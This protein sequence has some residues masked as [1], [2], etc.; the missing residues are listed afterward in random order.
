M[1][2]YDEEEE[3]GEEREEDV[4]VIGEYEG[5]RNEKCQRHGIGRALL[6]N[7]DYY[8]GRYN[9]GLRHGLGL[10]IFKNGARYN[11]RYSKGKKD[12]IGIFIYPDGTKYE[13]EWKDDDRHGYGIYYYANGDF[14]EGQWRKGIKEGL[15]CYFFKETGAKYLGLWKDGKMS[16]QG[17]QVTSN[18]RF[19]GNWVENLPYGNGCF[20]FSESKVIQHGFYLNIMG[21]DIDIPPAGFG[22][23]EEV[24]T[25]HPVWRPRE[26]T[27]FSASQLP[28]EPKPLEYPS[29]VSRS[30]S[31]E[32]TPPPTAEVCVKDF[33][34]DIAQYDKYHQ[35]EKLLWQTDKWDTEILEEIKKKAEK[36]PVHLSEEE[37]LMNEGYVTEQGI[38]EHE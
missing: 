22:E 30:P 16:G 34:K 15:G 1:S 37:D 23:E 9:Q 3:V 4:D 21:P 20:S 32:P 27:P 2:D 28:T 7:G 5:Q 26:I 10:Y 18:Y 8:E 19:Y 31:P 29:D 25:V 33:F 38:I 35:D 17:Q 12:G 13:G 11:G 14:Y 36:K 6:P 24:E